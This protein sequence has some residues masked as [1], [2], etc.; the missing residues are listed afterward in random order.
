[1]TRDELLDVLTRLRVAPV[2]GRR[3]PHKP[4]LLLWLFGRL[5]A[6]GTTRAS[7]LEARDE[8]ITV[9]SVRPWLQNEV[10]R[11]VLLDTWPRVAVHR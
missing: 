3:A 6:A 4:L 5:A 11:R 7:Y 1:M 9:A 10:V 2:G 8:Q